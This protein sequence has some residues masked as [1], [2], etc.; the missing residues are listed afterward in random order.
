[1]RIHTKG[2]NLLGEVGGGFSDG[3]RC[4]HQQDIE[5]FNWREVAVASAASAVA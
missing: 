1:M 2:W 3:V 4:R 5:K